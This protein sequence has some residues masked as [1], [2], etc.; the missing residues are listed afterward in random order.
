[1]GADR[2]LS[3]L[4]SSPAA[5]GFAGG[6]AG[7][8]ASS[9]LTSRAGRKLGRKALRVGGIA[10]V[11]G[12]AHAAYRHYRSGVDQP[13][14]PRDADPL[15]LA[16]FVPD[17]HSKEAEVLGLTLLK[18]MVA[19]ANA[20]GMLDRRER[21]AILER[22]GSLGLSEGERVELL[23]SL[24]RPVEMGELVAEAA[25]PEIAVEIY[26]ASLLAIELD[27]AAERGYMAML[28]ARL[29]LPEALVASIHRELG[30][31]PSVDSPSAALL[32][33]AS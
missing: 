8:L 11:G 19:A 4:L 21:Y 23:A 14:P 12:L 24:S 16:D 32:S 10:A 3:Q 26:T 17:P 28:A 15:S 29:G 18:A 25:T 27:T 7:G 31:P 5:S 33:A 13:A 30:V 6:L 2:I 20:D 9:L 22:V 1:M